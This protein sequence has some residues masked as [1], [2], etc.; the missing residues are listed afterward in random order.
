MAPYGIQQAI[1]LIFSSCDSFFFHLLSF[2][3]PILSHRRLDAFMH[4]IYFHTW[5]GLSANLEFRSKCAARGSLKIQD[6]KNHQKFAIS[7]HVLSFDYSKAFDTV[8]Y[9]TLMSKLAQLAIPDNIYNWI[10][11]FYQD[12]SHSTKFDGLDS[13]HRCRSSS[14]RHS[15][16][17]TRP[18]GSVIVTAA[19]LHPVHAG[20]RI[21]R[22]ADD[23]YLVVSAINSGTCNA[24]I[25]H[26]QTWAASNNLKMNH[27]KTMESVF[28]AR[29][30]QAPSPPCK[31]IE[32]VSSLRVLGVIINDKLTAADHV[33]TLLTSCSSLFYALRV[34]R[35]HGIPAQSLH[36]VFL[37]LSSLRSCDLLCTS[38]VGNVF[39]R[40]SC[41]PQLASA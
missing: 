29:R 3:S 36:D 9:D 40:W 16:L 38:M 32:R 19:D 21:F 8:R 30:T 20:N 2:S 34:L 25:E 7:V 11:N 13:I 18:S 5:C 23:T 26:M 17:G 39:S 28:T 4:T 33:S 14:Q 10:R 35:T 31:D 24:E 6:A 1:R 12:R 27:A 22:F 41:A 37:P 15:G